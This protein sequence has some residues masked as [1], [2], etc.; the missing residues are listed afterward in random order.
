MDILGHLLVGLGTA[1]SLSNLLYCFIGVFLGTVIGVLPGLG[2]VATISL[3][4]PLSYAMDPVSAVI[5]MA[6]IYYGAQYGGS[7]TSILVRI[8]GEASSV[9]T[10]L[11]GYAMARQGRAGAALGIAAFGS[12][13]AGIVSTAALFIVGPAMAELALAF[14]PAEYAALV[15]LGLLLVTQVSQTSKLNS[16][17]MVALGLLL[18]TVG[19]DPIYGTE[20][21]TFG[22]YSI[23]DGLNMA[24]LAMGLFG[25]AELLTMAEGSAASMPP[26]AQPKTLRELLPSAS[27]WKASALPMVRGTGLGF[28]LG[29][30]PGGGATLASFTTYVME[31]RLAKQPERFGNGAIEGVAGPEAANNAAAQAA[32]V[33]LLSLGIPANPVLGVILGA[34]LIQGITP[35][36]Q[37]AAARPEL[38]FGVMAS[39]LV[40][41]LM[42][43]VLNVPLIS[44]FVM[45]LRVPGSILAPLIIVFCVI[46]AYSLSNSVVEV[47][48]M[49]VF[50]IGGYL[51][52]K[53]DLDPAPLILA[54]VLGDILE[55][56]LRQALLVGRGTLILFIDRPIA[57][58]LI[59]A[60]AALILW[61][62]YE[63]IRDI[64]RL[65]A[66]QP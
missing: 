15:L 24:L 51:M 58:G 20:R 39:M 57:L 54:F 64:R 48:I 7:I 10:C 33:P 32:F 28:L 2:P 38:F 13:F 29:M 46:G 17:L 40:G 34:L 25:V 36:P 5:L 23:Y 3:L 56:S 65:S 19:I 43:V 18:A 44:V 61:Q 53:V 11:D 49:I 42:L 22:V 30:L 60:C 41:N 1:L 12:F 50:G 6:G 66:R 55:T 21:F 63:A 16:L 14:G 31:R 35:G 26:V 4:L 8:P 59:L 47:L 37:L 45:L 52:R 27:D 62:I 9:V